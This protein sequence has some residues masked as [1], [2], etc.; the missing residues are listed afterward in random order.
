MQIN[1]SKTCKETCNNF[2]YDNI[3]EGIVN[4]RESGTEQIRF[5]NVSSLIMNII[6]LYSKTADHYFALI[7]PCNFRLIEIW[8]EIIRP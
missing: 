5:C 6:H 8:N 3:M 2:I 7:L 1:H 4:F